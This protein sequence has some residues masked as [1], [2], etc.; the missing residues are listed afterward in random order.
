MQEIG[1][2]TSQRAV[3]SAGTPEKV[4]EAPEQQKNKVI[5]LT[6]RAHTGNA[7]FIYVAY[8]QNAASAGFGYVLAAGETLTID[9]HDV[10][11][12]FLD[13]SKIWVDASV[14]GDGISY[15]AIEVI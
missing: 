14:N 10:I 12:G 6:V 9:I 8:D 11:D 2:I 5:A 4:K 13:L 1:F 15:I 3:T 7:G